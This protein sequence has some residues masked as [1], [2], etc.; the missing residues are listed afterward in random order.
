MINQMNL[1]EGG[2]TCSL[3]DPELVERK[4]VLQKEIFSK[5]KSIEEVDNGYLFYFNDDDVTLLPNLF[6][7]I[8]AEKACC[9]FFRQDISIGANASGITWMISG[10]N[11]IKEMLRLTFDNVEFPDN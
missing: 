11:G 1:N 4:T 8:L 6:Q 3:T 9:P 2:F 10:E 7:Y 5:M